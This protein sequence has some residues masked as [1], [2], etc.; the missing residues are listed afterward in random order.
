MQFVV[1]ALSVALV[2]LAT[3][4]RAAPP[5]R[6]EAASCSAALL[7][8][9]ASRGI[10]QPERC[11]RK[12]R[13]TNIRTQQEPAKLYSVGRRIEPA[14]LYSVG[15][16]VRPPT[17]SFAGWFISGNV[18]GNFSALDQTEIFKMTNV[19]TNRFSDSSQTVGFGFNAGYLFAPWNNGILVG[20][21]ASVDVLNQD[22]SHTFPGGFFLGQTAGVIGSVNAQ[23]GFVGTPHFLIYGEAGPAFVRLDQKLNFSGPVTSVDTWATGVN[24][25]IGAAYEPP[26]WQ[27][28]GHRLAIFSQ[29]NRIFLPSVTFDNPGSPGF[30]YRNQND[31]VQLKFGLRL[32]LGDGEPRAPII[33]DVPPVVRPV[34]GFH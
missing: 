29:V 23:L 32:E 14:K 21:S 26:D 27:F 19:V 7:A 3:R 17:A 2:G 31:I 11:S 28:A 9:Y 25:G 34:F 22:T 10:A 15:T 16:L 24:V 8:D 20:A 1:V 6:A 30:I 18:S 33:H 12:P 13:T 4:A 5:A